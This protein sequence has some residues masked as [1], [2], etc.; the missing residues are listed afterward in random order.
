[1]A[2][3]HLKASEWYEENALVAEA[4]RHALSA[5]DHERAARL[6]ES[7]VGQTWYRGEV[8]TLLGWLR[9]LPEE[10]MRR[11]PLLLV[12]YAA[13]LMLVGRLEG[14]ESLLREAEGAVGAAGVAQGEDDP[15]HVLATAAA[16]RSMHARLQGDP[17]CAIEHARRALVLLPADNLDPRPFAAITLAQA[18]EAAGDLE[19]ASAAFAEA[20]AL[21][22]AAGHDYVAL[23]AMA[24]LAHLQLARGRLREADGVLRRALGFAAERGSGLLPAVGSVRIGMGELLYEWD[25]L[26][27]AARHLAE[28]VELAGRTGDF[29]ILMWGH[30]ALSQVRRA[31]G[32][33][34]GALA[35]AREAERV[36]QGSGTDHAI[37]DA[38][39]WRARLHLM[40]GDLTAAAFEQ[41]RAAGVGEVRPY[42]RTLERIT[43]ARLLL[44]RNQPGEAL[45]LL[46]RLRASAQTAGR[47]IVM[48]ALQALALRAKGEKERAVST[49]AEALALAEPEGYVRTFVDE[50][51][52]MAELLSGVLEAQQ[53][54]R[55]DSPSR[56]PAHYLRKLLAALERDASGAALPAAE[57][58]EPLSD[59]EREV[60]QLIAAGKTNRRIASE[61]FVSV[62]TVKTHI[63]N[64][65]RKL[66]AHSRTQ[67]VARAR[68]LDLI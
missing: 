40:S 35:A 31:Q 27:A 65:Y 64:L 26:D 66:D 16:V 46:A 68:E 8:V 17:R 1:L 18:F 58:P 22:R 51:S 36:A 3:L 48:L 47:T 11:R 6:M 15:Q 7:G 10:A 23:S 33:A 39:T 49:L 30:I 54:G 38:A 21:G 45:R 32:D 28:G 9:K 29:E 52:E 61:L 67:A 34:E 50:G 37:V 4:V 20:G 56:V 41:E 44:A 53:R 24:S 55:L 25:E 63:N 13:A 12:W 2:P 57:L 60:L 5:G 19:A 43:L 14:V 62:G 42:S 59:R